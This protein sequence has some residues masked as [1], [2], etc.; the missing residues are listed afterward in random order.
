M[1]LR[2]LLTLVIAPLLS[3]AQV[4]LGAGY[5]YSNFGINDLKKSPYTTLHAKGSDIFSFCAFYTMKNDIQVGLEYSH[6]SFKFKDA[7]FP[8]GHVTLGESVNVYNAAAN[9]LFLDRALC[10]YVGVEAGYLTATNNNI[11]F[12]STSNADGFVFGANLGLGFRVYRGIL[13]NAQVGYMK[14]WISTDDKGNYKGQTYSLHYVPATIGVHY[15][16]MRSENKSEV[17]S[18]LPDQP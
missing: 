12:Y 15:L 3:N 2:L 16:F 1:K 17:V 6:T 13:L 14:S 9:Y 11:A 8:S 4:E 10:P 7:S 18:L 5:G